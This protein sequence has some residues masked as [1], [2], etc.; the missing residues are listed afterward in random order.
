MR[1]KRLVIGNWTL[2]IVILALW[3]PVVALGKPDGTDQAGAAEASIAAQ[4]IGKDVRVTGEGGIITLEGTVDSLER[5]E[6][7]EKV[8]AGIKGVSGVRNRLQV[9]GGI[10]DGQIAQDAARKVRMYSYYGIF[11]DIE[12][13]VRDGKLILAGQVL[14]PWRRSDLGTIMKGVAGV[15]E[16]EN[17]LE[18]LPLS[19]YDD[20]I[21]LRLALAIYRHS[22]L[23]RYGMGA[24]PSIHIIVKNGNV[25]LTGVVGTEME[26]QLAGTVARVAALY[27]GFVNDLRTEDELRRKG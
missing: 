10:D 17:R 6:R 12:L 16:I 18:V 9:G 11:D 2:L 8:V 26:K 4:K 14:T 7:V 3:A 20:E 1:K 25:R 5:M 19:T 24:N 22:L 27:F 13:E 23:S 21:R 15:H